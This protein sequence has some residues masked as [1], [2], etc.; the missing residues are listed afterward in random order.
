[1]SAADVYRTCPDL[2]DW[3]LDD[4]PPLARTILNGALCLDGMR[5]P[6]DEDPTSR[7]L[8]PVPPQQQ[9]L[10]LRYR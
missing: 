1:M 5:F 8:E 3:T 2:S 10:R 9:Q 4:I 6:T 7:T